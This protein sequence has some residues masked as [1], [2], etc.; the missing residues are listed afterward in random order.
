MRSRTLALS[1][2]G[3]AQHVLVDPP[4]GHGAGAVRKGMT[5][6]ILSLSAQLRMSITWDEGREMARHVH[7]TVAT[8]V[9]IYSGDPVIR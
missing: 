6:R 3:R 9:K 1:H 7:Y 5:E 4:N 8:D 2:R